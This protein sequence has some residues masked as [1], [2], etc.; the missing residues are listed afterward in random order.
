MT[1]D[2]AVGE[3]AFGVGVGEAGGQKVVV[4]ELVED[5]PGYEQFP[6]GGAVEAQPWEG[7]RHLR[8]VAGPPVEASR[9]RESCSVTRKDHRSAL[10]TTSPSHCL[11][12]PSVP[13][14]RSSSS[15]ARPRG[16]SVPI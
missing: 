6:S 9:T 10:A 3:G 15:T 11:N 2:R 16:E 7:F 5:H 4:A 14:V 13:D 12:T 1:I 8:N